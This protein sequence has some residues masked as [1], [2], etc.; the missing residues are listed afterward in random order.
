MMLTNHSKQLH[1]FYEIDQKE[2]LRIFPLKLDRKLSASLILQ[3]QIT[4]RTNIIDS[5]REN[6]YNLYDF[7]QQQSYS[8]AGN[9]KDIHF[10]VFK[11][12]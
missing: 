9:M 7:C 1:S 3:K 10:I 11:Y 12:F 5:E 2:L 8:S 4:L 6:E